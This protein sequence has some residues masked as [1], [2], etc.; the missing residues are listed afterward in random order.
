MN[1]RLRQNPAYRPHAITRTPLP[2]SGGGGDFLV[3][4]KEL[5]VLLAPGYYYLRVAL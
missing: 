1:G 5:S 2:P 4:V 3:I